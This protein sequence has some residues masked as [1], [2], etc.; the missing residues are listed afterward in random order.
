MSSE[1]RRAGGLAGCRVAAVVGGGRR[2]TAL[3]NGR[4]M[5]L[6][7]ESE[8]GLRLERIEPHAAVLRY[9]GELRRFIVRKR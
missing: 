9:K 2:G 4:V 5:V 1:P 3:I 6:G 8:E 7:E